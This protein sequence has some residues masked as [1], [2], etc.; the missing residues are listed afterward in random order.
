MLAR[1]GAFSEKAR[2]MTSCEKKTTFSIRGEM[3]TLERLEAFSKVSPMEE[4]TSRL[5]W[6][7]LAV[8]KSA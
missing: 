7:S 4:G 6:V 2:S 5:T 3:D 1:E 8:V